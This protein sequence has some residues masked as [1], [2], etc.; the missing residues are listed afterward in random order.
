MT[1]IELPEKVEGD[2]CHI[3]LKAG[4]P[5]YIQLDKLTLCHEHYVII[6]KAQLEYVPKK[7]PDSVRLENEK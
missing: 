2:I 4:L 3:C 7:K 1:S 5:L 6:N